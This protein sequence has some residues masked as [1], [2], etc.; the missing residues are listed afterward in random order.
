MACFHAAMFPACL[1]TISSGAS[2]HFQ[3]ICMEFGSAERLD[4]VFLRP[5]DTVS[6]RILPAQQQQPFLSVAVLV[7]I[8]LCLFNLAAWRLHLVVLAAMTFRQMEDCPVCKRART[9][10]FW[11]PPQW[12]NF[13]AG[14][15]VDGWYR[16]C[17][18]D[19]STVP[20]W[21]FNEAG[22]K[23]MSVAADEVKIPSHVYSLSL[24]EV[25][26][27]WVQCFEWL[28]SKIPSRFW[29]LFQAYIAHLDYEHK[30]AIQLK[31]Q[32]SLLKHMSHF[33]AI[34]VPKAVPASWIAWRDVDNGDVY[35]D[36]MNSVYTSVIKRCWP[37]SSLATGPYNK[38]TVGDHAEA[39]LGYQW[40]MRS[41]KKAI[42]PLIGMFITQFERLCF[43]TYVRDHHTKQ[44][45]GMYLLS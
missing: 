27:S 31:G 44:L 4:F 41:N 13:S 43:V 21:Y 38:E 15:V 5:P 26:S 24:L 34:R 8:A 20:G 33:G 11:S 12:K 23:S 10:K 22:P 36:P 45:G 9:S 28:Q 7:Q 14:V 19:C 2:E 16:N 6:P 35:M 25:E 18:R 29:D 32:R 37:Q 42:D 1:N 40:V 39:F 30:A 17:C 3:Q